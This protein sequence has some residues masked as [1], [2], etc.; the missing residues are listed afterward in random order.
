MWLNSINTT[1]S[2]F[3]AFKRH[4]ANP[5]APSDSL[6]LDHA[7]RNIRQIWDSV[8]FQNNSSWIKTKKSTCVMLCAKYSG[9]LLCWIICFVSNTNK[10]AKE[11]NT[12]ILA[13][14][15]N[16]HHYLKVGKQLLCVLLLYSASRACVICQIWVRPKE[17]NSSDIFLFLTDYK[18]AHQ[19]DGGTVTCATPPEIYN[20]LWQMS[21]TN[22]VYFG[23]DVTTSWIGPV[24]FFCVERWDGFCRKLVLRK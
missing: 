24:Y 10:F 13:H 15:H 9:L 7:A 21:E 11:Q 1:Q 3:V 18:A 2:N 8:H 12:H 5:D 22:N 6:I 14:T 17:K 23:C 16:Q 4:K 19:E 20:S